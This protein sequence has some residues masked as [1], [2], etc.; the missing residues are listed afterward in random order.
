MAAARAAP[1]S[2]ELKDMELSDIFHEFKKGVKE[3]LGD[4]DHETHYNLGIAYREMGLI[5]EAIGEFQLAIK[6]SERIFDASSM[7]ALCFKEKGMHQ[8]AVTQ[9]KR[10]ID[11]PR[12]N[13]SEFL[14][15]KYDLGVIYEEMGLMEE[16]YKAFMD[17]YGIDVNFRDVAEKIDKLKGS[18]ASKKKIKEDIKLVEK[19][20]APE[21]IASKII[22]EEPEEPEPIIVKDAEAAASAKKSKKGKVSYI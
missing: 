8:L 9:L 13:E 17:A 21:K 12:Y 14:S 2:K 22:D 3:Y 10:A 15:L 16:A 4:E 1:E 19:R 5:N 11:D 7:L 18:H 20:K 6:G